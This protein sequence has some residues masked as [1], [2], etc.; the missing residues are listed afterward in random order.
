MKKSDEKKIPA[1]KKLVLTLESIVVVIYVVITVLFVWFK[2]DRNGFITYFSANPIVRMYL[3]KTTKA[4][5]EEKV[6]DMDYDKDKVVVNEGLSENMETYRNIALFGIDSRGSEFDD[7][8]HSDTII[9]LSINN[10]TKE[11]SRN[12]KKSLSLHAINAN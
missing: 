4:D 12:L 7:S 8:A 3:N 6:Q 11:I 5:Y 10:K 2:Q 9:V 1:W